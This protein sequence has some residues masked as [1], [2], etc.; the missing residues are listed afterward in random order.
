MSMRWALNKFSSFQADL[1]RGCGRQRRRKNRLNMGTARH[2]HAVLRAKS[3][4]E[5]RK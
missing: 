2:F 1:D 5:A 3:I 4:F